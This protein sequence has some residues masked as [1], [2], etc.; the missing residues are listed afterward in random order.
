MNRLNLRSFT[1]FTIILISLGFI[2]IIPESSKPENTKKENNFE[3][4]IYDWTRTFA[5]VLQTTNEKHYKIP[6]AEKCMIAAINGFLSNTDPHSA[7]F[8]PKEYKDIMESTSGQFYGIGIVIDNTRNSKDKFLTVVDTVPDGPADSAG[9]QPFDKIIEVEG[10]KLDGLST[11]EITAL[12]KGE[13]NT[14]VQVK[15]LREGE[16]DLLEFDITRDIV[17]QQNSLCFYLPQQH[18]YYLALST[19]TQNAINQMQELLKKSKEKQYKGLIIDLRNNSGGLLNAV[20]DIAGMILDKNSLVVTT[21]NK[22][23]K[24]TGRYAT[25]NDPIINNTL[26]IFILINNYTASAA[27]IL[28]GALKIHSQELAKKPGRQKKLMVFIVGEKTFGKGSV[29]EVIPIGNNCGMKITTSLYFLAQDTP[30]QALGVEPDFFIKRSLPQTKQM[31]WLTEFYGRETTLQNHI[32]PNGQ[33]DKNEENNIKKKTDK[34]T[35]TWS[36]RAKQLL[37]TDNQLRAAINL[38]N[39]LNVAQTCCPDKVKN[40]EEAVSFLNQNFITD[41]KIKMEEV[42]I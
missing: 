6:N 5:K 33:V 11:E 42:H 29:Q 22:F 24:E 38:I 3:E 2:T 23:D 41:K 12:I 28:A 13:R 17:K 14:Q 31:E 39:L 18:I 10:K 4:Q 30:V 37:A 26:P 36:K 32:K 8:P 21:K 19:F 16:K 25:T 34:K 7:F 1:I 20:V 9:M 27:E 15:V 35:K 40:R